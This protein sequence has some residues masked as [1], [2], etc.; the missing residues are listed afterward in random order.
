MQIIK[1][2]SYSVNGLVPLT[3]PLTRGAPLL[4]FNADGISDISPVL[5]GNCPLGEAFMRL[6]LD[7]STAL[8]SAQHDGDVKGARNNN[9]PVIL[10]RAYKLDLRRI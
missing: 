9:I 4:S 5:R 7:V 2:Q 1:H 6:R 10:S 3:A 8:R